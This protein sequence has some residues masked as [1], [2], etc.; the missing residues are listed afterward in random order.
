MPLTTLEMVDD[1][2]VALINSLEFL[3]T[4]FIGM[5]QS[6]SIDL[7]NPMNIID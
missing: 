1:E 4:A 5:V 7:R 2:V 3:A 6:E